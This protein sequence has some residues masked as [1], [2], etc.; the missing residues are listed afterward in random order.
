MSTGN[1]KID[2]RVE[3]LCMHGCKA[4]RGYIAALSAGEDLPQAHDL[5]AHER[6]QLREELSAIM[7]V[8]GDTCRI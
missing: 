7:A 6:E 3:E 4:V 5:D 2:R 1:P 8:Y